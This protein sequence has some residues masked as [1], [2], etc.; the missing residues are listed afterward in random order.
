MRNRPLC[1]LCLVF[2]ILQSILL[3]LEGGNSA[4]EVPASSVFSKGEGQMVTVQGQVYRKSYTSKV[5]ILYLKNN[6]VQDSNLLI[7][8]E[9]F[10][11]APIGTTIAIKGQTTPFERARN[12]GNFDRAL[13]YAK[14]NIYGSIWCEEVLG[15]SGEKNWLLDGLHELKMHWK[16]KLLEATGEKNG[17]ILAAML[18]GEKDEMDEEVKELYQKTGIGH[19]LAISGLHISFIGLG[20][21]RLL[22]ELGLPYVAAGLISMSV[23]GLYVF[24]IGFTVSVIRAFVMLFLR[25]GADMTGRVYDMV[26][27][28]SLAAALTIGKQPLYLTDTGFYFSY[29]AIVGIVCVF[30]ALQ[31]LCGGRSKYWSGL[32]TSLSVNI[33][34]FPVLLWY[35]FEFP[36][37]S[38]FLNFIVIPLMSVVLS[39]GMVGSFFLLWMAPVGKWCLTGCGLILDLFET[40][41]RI[42]SRLPLARMV[43]GQPDMW[44]VIFYYVVLFLMLLYIYKCKDCCKWKR[45]KVSLCL[46]FAGLLWLVSYRSKEDL[47]I[48]MLDVGQGDS[49]FLQGPDGTAYLIDGGSSDVDELGKYRIEPYLKSQGVGE[50]DYVFVTHGDADHYSGILEMLE[51]QSVGVRIRSVV[52]PCHFRQDEALVDLAKEA[53]KAGTDVLVMGAGDRLQDGN[54]LITCVQPASEEKELTGNAG[55]LVLD[56][57]FGAFSMLCTGDV[58]GEGEERLISNLQGKTYDVLKVAHH[59]SRHSTSEAFLAAVQP[60]LALISSGEGNRYGHPHKETLSRMETCGCRIYQTEKLGAITLQIRGNSLTILQLPYR[61]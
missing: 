40:T 54:F 16:A 45:Q 27:A 59:G 53:K 25:I 15:M 44:K 17:A 56:I 50:L 33:V 13:Y 42:G 2:L 29:G 51:R 43:L 57:C 7:Y 4:F 32:Y 49:I 61:L 55:S 60:Q 37:Y 6:S 58:E 41:S 38:V 24:M 31:K 3:L 10:I 36:T 39:L 52:L 46:I 22:R 47:Q 8:D 19:V 23:L 35:Y 5:Q 18:L 12:P 9:N 34:L 14:E 30:P 20:L 26:T 48:T 11:D 28:L 1:F 21:Y